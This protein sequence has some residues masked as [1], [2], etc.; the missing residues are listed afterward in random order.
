MLF[1]SALLPTI[2]L[3][4]NLM[5]SNGHLGHLMMQEVKPKYLAIES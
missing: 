4:A 3:D 2:E 1:F 5:V